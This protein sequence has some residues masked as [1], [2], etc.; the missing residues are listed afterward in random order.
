MSGRTLNL[1][2]WFLLKDFGQRTGATFCPGVT[3]AEVV[4]RTC[5][6]SYCAREIQHAIRFASE[7]ALR[8]HSHS[9]I[10]VKCECGSIKL[11]GRLCRQSW[12]SLVCASQIHGALWWTYW[13]LAHENWDEDTPE[14]DS[15][16]ILVLCISRKSIASPPVKGPLRRLAKIV[17]S[18][19]LQFWT[20]W[21]LFTS[22][23]TVQPRAIPAAAGGFWEM[24]TTRTASLT[25]QL[26][27]AVSLCCSQEL[28]RLPGVVVSQRFPETGGGRLRRFAD[29]TC[30]THPSH[31]GTSRQNLT[32]MAKDWQ[33]IKQSYGF[34]KGNWSFLPVHKN[35]WYQCNVLQNVHFVD[36]RWNQ[37]LLDQ[38]LMIRFMGRSLNDCQLDVMASS[39]SAPRKSPQATWKHCCQA[40]FNETWWDSCCSW[41][42]TCW[43]SKQSNV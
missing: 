23:Y 27:I 16:I 1:V 24:F 5:S 6:F 11:S 25:S 22:W 36:P 33:K 3:L 14:D 31:R 37:H 20:W 15:K 28:Q 10:C 43:Y 42:M 2:V 18:L 29:R 26:P 4:G 13:N 40:F 38:I 35:E 34:E 39:L 17:N 32:G 7:V 21:K 12:T 30:F 8:S 41:N 9:L 19:F